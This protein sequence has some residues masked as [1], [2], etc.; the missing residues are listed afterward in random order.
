MKNTNVKVIWITG[1]SG[2]GKTTIANKL[3]S[4]LRKDGK[5]VIMLDGDLLRK[6]FG[7]LIDNKKKF[8]SKT[9]FELAMCYA[10]MC[11]QIASQGIYVVIA[12]ISMFH[13]IHKVL[14]VYGLLTY[15]H[16]GLLM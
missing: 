14:L 10:K 7:T 16:F 3:T 6:A 13:K 5:P 12:T 15:L 1:L 4:L 9:R 8:S 11:K 2:S